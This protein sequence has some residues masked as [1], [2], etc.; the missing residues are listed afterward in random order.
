MGRLA[1]GAAL[2]CPCIP[3]VPSFRPQRILSNMNTSRPYYGYLIVFLSFIIMCVQW[4]VIYSF[5]VFLKPLIVEFGWTRAMTAGAFSISSIIGGLTTIYMGWLNDRYG[6]RVVMSI[7]GFLLG[8][9]CILLSQTASLVYYY[10]SFGI[11]IGLSMGGQFAPLM[12]TIARWFIARRGMMSGIVAAGMGVGGLIGP[13]IANLLISNY[14][15]RTAYVIIGSASLIA[16]MASA[17]FIRREPTPMHPMEA[18]I[19]P[20][21]SNSLE[22]TDRRIA[23][24][25]AARDRQ[26]WL[27]VFTGFC[28]GYALF[29]LA[30][31]VVV[32]AMDKGLSS[33]MAVGVLSTLMGLS[34]LGKLFFGRMLDTIGSK[35]NML[36]GF[37][38]LGAVYVFLIFAQTAESIYIGAAIFGF[39]YGA[40]TV[41]IS[42]MTAAL[43]GL[44]SHGMIMGFHGFFVT[45]GGA[46]GPYFTGYIYDHSGDYNTAF[47]IG[48]AICILGCT[49][50]AKIKP[51]RIEN[52]ECKSASAV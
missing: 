41:S 3:S 35:R 27:F 46:L 32:H 10:F 40:I 12:S 28:Y 14:G 7:C 44:R 38:M 23:P 42:P 52:N 49:A 15:W 22:T 50:T 47:V 31:H 11:I 17:Q 9:G 33:M 1:G 51:R 29:S 26:F 4:G 19:S 34:I 2:Q 18:G 21:G 20:A 37:F 16:I 30:V 48:I 24:M 36:V 5:G 25:Q 45:L 39:S 13:Q 6:P 8:L 43:F